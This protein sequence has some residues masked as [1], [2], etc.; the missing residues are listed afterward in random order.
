MMGT[1]TLPA[2]QAAMKFLCGGLGSSFYHE[3]VAQLAVDAWTHNRVAL[4]CER[5]K[6]LI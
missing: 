1:Y 4:G 3:T 5:T 6:P 2:V